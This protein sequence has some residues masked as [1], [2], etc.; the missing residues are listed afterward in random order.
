[1]LTYIIEAL[2]TSTTTKEAVGK[3]LIPDCAI[4]NE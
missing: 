2:E 4:H 1:M 3:L